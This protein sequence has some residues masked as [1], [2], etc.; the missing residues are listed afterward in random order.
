M[1]FCLNVPE[2]DVLLNS[3]LFLCRCLVQIQF[4]QTVS[5]LRLCGGFVD[6]KREKTCCEGFVQ[7]LAL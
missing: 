6:N 7:F 5:T 1:A 3:P 2:I 4:Y